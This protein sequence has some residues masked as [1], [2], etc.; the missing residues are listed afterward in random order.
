VLVHNDRIIGEGY[1]VVFGGKHAEVNALESVITADKH[2]I[3]QSTMYVSMEPCAHFGKTPPCAHRLVEEGIRTV[4]VAVEDPNPMVAGKGIAYLRENGVDVEIDICRQEAIDLNKSFFHFHQKRRPYITLKFAQ[5]ADGFIAETG[6]QAVHL[7]S[8]ESDTLVHKMRA[9]NQAILVGAATAISDD[10]L[11]TVRHWKGRDPLRLVL[12]D[13]RP[14]PAGLRMFN[15]GGA[16]LFVTLN[17]AEFATS[18]SAKMQELHIISLLVEGGLETLELFLQNG[19]WDE[20]YRFTA[21]A[22]LEGGI[23]APRIS[24]VPQ[25][26]TSSGI[27]HLDYYEH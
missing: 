21:P 5:S 9:E 1:H 16:T 18:F 27:D 24:W 22:K 3:P 19:L 14:L 7:T 11:L 26:S 20:M 15:D 25:R 10:P 17:A 12:G 2:L 13:D 6:R 23:P 4:V 8:I